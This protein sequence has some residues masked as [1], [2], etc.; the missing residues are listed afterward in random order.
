M[1]ALRFRK[2]VHLTVMLDEIALEK[3]IRWD[4]RTNHFLGICREHAHNVGLEFNGEKDLDE[5][6]AALEKKVDAEGKEYSLV[7][8]APEV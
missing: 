7:H 6:M 2:V 8:S 5:L 4:P 3:R 1:E